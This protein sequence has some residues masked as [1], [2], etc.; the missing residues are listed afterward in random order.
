MQELSISISI[1]FTCSSVL[2]T[3]WA[4]IML[5]FAKG[6]YALGDHGFDEGRHLKQLLVK[7]HELPLVLYHP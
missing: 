1:E 2:I 7:E 5:P 3:S 6:L 4:R